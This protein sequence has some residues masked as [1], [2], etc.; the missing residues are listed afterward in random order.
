[1]LFRSKKKLVP[2]I[3]S[4]ELFN[5]LMKGLKNE[6]ILRKKDNSIQFMQMISTYVNQRTWEKYCDLEEEE[7]IQK[8][9]GI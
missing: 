8:V 7:P 2:I 1:M 6:L 9:E 5:K 4:E 3:K